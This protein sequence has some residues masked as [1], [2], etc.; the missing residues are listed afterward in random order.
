MQ[1]K[2][3]GNFEVVDFNKWLEDCILRAVELTTK[4]VEKDFKDTYLSGAYS[5][6][7]LKKLDHP[8]A[9]RHYNFLLSIKNPSVIARLL[10]GKVF[11]G[12]KLDVV[13]IQEGILSKSLSR[14]KTEKTGNKVVGKVKISI[15]KCPY[16]KYVFYGTSRMIPRP[17]HLI[18]A[19]Y[20]KNEI[21]KIFNKKLLTI[22]KRRI[23]AFMKK[24]KVQ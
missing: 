1:F 3:K 4:Y 9:R 14:I 18:Y 2:L 19:I 5:L 6:E 8:F 10:K 11:K 13:N 7:M 17:V 16:A 21:I 20:H 22:A 15:E 23:N 12:V 24:Y